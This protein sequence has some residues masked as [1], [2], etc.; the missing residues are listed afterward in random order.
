MIVYG[1]VAM[2][3][4]TTTA[5]FHLFITPYLLLLFKV[6]LHGKQ[7][8]AR[9]AEASQNWSGQI[10][11]NPPKASHTCAFQIFVNNARKDIDSILQTPSFIVFYIFFAISQLFVFGDMVDFFAKWVANVHKCIIG[12]WAQ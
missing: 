3:T 6:P 11:G 12:I 4:V 9:V 2:Q 1:F 5:I 7:H 10:H 8:F